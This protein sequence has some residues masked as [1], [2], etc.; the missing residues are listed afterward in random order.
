M[1][2]SLRHAKDVILG[3]T[4][5]YA[6]T[7]LNH[8]A[9]RIVSAKG[10]KTCSDVTRV[11]VLEYRFEQNSHFSFGHVSIWLMTVAIYLLSV[12]NET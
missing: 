5:I 9:L 12:V 1:A 6:G 4:T 8:I 10:L 2:I 3:N 7:R 11:L